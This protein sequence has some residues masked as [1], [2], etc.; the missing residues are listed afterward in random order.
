[1][2]ATR[3]RELRRSLEDRLEAEARE[4]GMSPLERAAWVAEHVEEY[5]D[6]WLGLL[7]LPSWSWSDVVQHDLLGT[8]SLGADLLTRELRQ[9]EPSREALAAWAAF[10]ATL[11]DV[12]TRGGPSVA[13]LLL[14][15]AREVRSRLAERQDREG[16]PN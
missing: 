7:A 15:A 14:D 3:R 13:P 10:L 1:M 9:A 12:Q 6:R 4:R 2:D 11:D 16:G 5:V 8:V